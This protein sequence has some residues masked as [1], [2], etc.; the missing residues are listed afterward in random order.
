M[1]PRWS[2]LLA[3]LLCVLHR[4]GGE[5]GSSLV[6]VYAVS[7]HGARNVLPKSSTLRE[8]PGGVTLL[9]LGQR[10]CF[11][12]GVAFRARYLDAGCAASGDAAPANTCLS[13]DSQ[14]D[15]GGLYGVVGA[16]GVTWC[17]QNVLARS[18][19]LDRTLLSARS[20]LAG[21]SRSALAARAAP[22]RAARLRC[23]Q[24]R[25]ALR[26]CGAR[27]ADTRNARTGACAPLA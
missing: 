11:N 16:P 23:T 10:Q 7:R 5:T 2:A 4:A 3:A 1:R 9:P 26:A 6:L 8:P 27:S 21:A 13:P 24:R 19:A 20:F 12:A 22:M 14:S 17:N 15:S 25:C 18:S